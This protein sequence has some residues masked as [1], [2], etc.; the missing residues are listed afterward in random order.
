MNTIKRTITKKKPCHADSSLNEVS[1]ITFEGE[2]GKFYIV[3]SRDNPFEGVYRTS[4]A[5]DKDD[6]R[7]LAKSLENFLK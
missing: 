4:I 3:V 5:L 2:K 6:A 7:V 1:E